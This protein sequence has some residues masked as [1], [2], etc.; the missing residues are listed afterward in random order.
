MHGKALD[1]EPTHKLTHQKLVQLW[2]ARHSDATQLE[3]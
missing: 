2:I 1:F 3:L